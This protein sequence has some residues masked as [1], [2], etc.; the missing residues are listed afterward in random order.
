MSDGPT[1][2]RLRPKLNPVAGNAAPAEAAAAAPPAVPP[3]GASPPDAA[4]VATGASATPPATPPP[5]PGADPR[6]VAVEA[7]AARSHRVTRIALVAAALG[8]AGVLV[9]AVW[10]LPRLAA[11]RL[12]QVRA[13]QSATSAPAPAPTPTSAAPHP[14]HAPASPASAAAAPAGALADRP[15][16]AAAPPPRAEP[17]PEFR[18]WVL[19]VKIAGLRTGDSPRL[20]ISGSAYQ[21]GDIVNR[22]HGIAFAGYDPARRML[23]FND[24]NGAVVERRHP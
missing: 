8:A 14:A 2:L 7:A 17:S 19:A 10:V 22:E 1:I 16:V 18:A 13:M 5:A 20:L 9:A 21:V 4:P 6:E 12:E 23:L 15:A 24:A 11:R 3:A